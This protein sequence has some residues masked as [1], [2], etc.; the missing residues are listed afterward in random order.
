MTCRCGPDDNEPGCA[1][2]MGAQ[3]VLATDLAAA[4]ALAEADARRLQG[5]L[6]RVPTREL[7][8]WLEAEM[9]CYEREPT[10]DEFREAIDAAIDAPQAEG[11][12][13]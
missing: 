3:Y 10:L 2:C 9:K 11:E 13:S 1:H 5:V 12:D 8:D 6:D 7:N 4:I